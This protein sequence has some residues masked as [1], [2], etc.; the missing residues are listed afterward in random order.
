MNQ[1]LRPT[2]FNVVQPFWINLGV[3]LALFL[4]ASFFSSEPTILAISSTVIIGFFFFEPFKLVLIYTVLIFYRDI[5]VGAVFGIKTGLL[6]YLTLSSN[7]IFVLLLA[8]L[9]LHNV[10]LQWRG[11]LFW[12]I[13]FFV[14]VMT[15]SCLFSSNTVASLQVLFRLVQ[16]VGYFFILFTLLDSERRIFYF[17]LMLLGI[18]SIVILVSGFNFLSSGDRLAHLSRFMVFPALASG[19]Y[20]FLTKDPRYKWFTGLLIAI[21]VFGSLSLIVTESR[22][23][24]M[25]LAIGWVFFLAVSRTRVG[26][27]I[28]IVLLI[29]VALVYA[30]KQSLS[31][32]QKTA[33]AL[34][35][36]QTGEELNEEETFDLFTGRDKLWQLG[37]DKFYE[38]PVFGIGLGISKEAVGLEYGKPLRL[39]N[40]YLEMLVETGVIGFFAFLILLLGF[41]SLSIK[42][43]RL[44]SK[45]N[46]FYY[47]LAATMLAITVIFFV[48]NYF[49]GASV[50]EKYEWVFYAI[51]AA[52]YRVASLKVKRLEVS[53]YS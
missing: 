43:I 14:S 25:A 36:L 44:H 51:L 49:G 37:L 6:E 28:F 2:A 27:L 17:L 48:T 42:L 4:A 7:Y 31:R 21:A 23:V 10:Q 46:D 19:L 3:F 33:V 30:P 26:A 53:R 29:V 5:F 45:K 8:S 18:F 13:V 20:V 50:F 38:S 11:P 52:G 24:I 47:Y 12:P 15:V 35:L 22:R 39:H 40:I 41:F 1:A 34:E 16:L 32:F 9:L